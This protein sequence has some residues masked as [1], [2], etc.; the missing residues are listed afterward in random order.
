VALLCEATNL[1]SGEAVLEIGCGIARNATSIFRKFGDDIHYLG[2]DIVKY[3]IEWSNKH[4]TRLQ[5][6][7]RKFTFV[8]ADI[9]NSFYNPRGG[10]SSE[11]YLFPAKDEKFDLVFATSVFTH[12]QFDETC[13]YL[14]EAFRVLKPGASVC[15]TAFLW[16]VDSKAIADQELAAFSFK[17]AA[18]NGRIQD[19]EEPDLAV[20]H[21]RSKLLTCLKALGFAEIDTQEGSWRGQPSNT[22]QDFVTA[23]KSK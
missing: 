10:V 2:F 20:A 6:D 13:H 15:F 4:F 5:P 3:G 9:R 14:S 19:I 1:K 7:D 21:D 8:H 22:F 18:L 12:M 16:D 17:H 23:T 11:D